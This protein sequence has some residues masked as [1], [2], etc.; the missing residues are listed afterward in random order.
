MKILA[1]DT[2][3]EYLSLALWCEGVVTAHAQWAGQAHSSL[4]LPALAKLLGETGLEL[5][6][7]DGIA[8][9]A[10]PGSFTGLRIACGVAQ[11]LAYGTGLPVVGIGTLLALAEA[12][13]A[14]KA[15]AC[16]DARMGEVYHAAYVRCEGGWD[17]IHAP[18]L[19]VP[20]RVP[21]VAGEGWCGVGSG[22]AAHGST[23]QA[24]YRDQ[25]A[26]VQPRIFPH[27]QAMVALAVPLFERGEGRSARD[28]APV[29]VRNKVAL[30]LR[31]RETRWT[32]G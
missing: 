20:E 22:W 7:L 9:G 8:F 18:G 23:L 11:G 4:I 5:R 12:S 26:S 15:I 19:Y 30:T 6:A 3:T 28:A 25:I 32:P 10:G 1:F 14:D 2:S 29:Y 24:C 13:G 17:E 21:P 27:A 16:L 31:E